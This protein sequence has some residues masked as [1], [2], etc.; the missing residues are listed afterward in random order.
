V[1]EDLHDEEVARGEPPRWE[2][3]RAGAAEDHLK[4]AVELG[5]YVTAITD[6][7]ARSPPTRCGS[8]RSA[9]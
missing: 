8:G 5:L 3:V 9:C 7:E 2:E 1:L 6:L 4:A